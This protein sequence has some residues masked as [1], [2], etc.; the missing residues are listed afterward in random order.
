[1]QA[2]CHCQQQQLAALEERL[3]AAT[4]KLEQQA[5]AHEEASRRAADKAER[6]QQQLKEQLT[7]SEAAIKVGCMELC[8]EVTNCVERQGWTECSTA[9]IASGWCNSRHV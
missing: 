2:Q 1:V 9:P 7:A 3:A 8:S 5:H 4:R 6:R